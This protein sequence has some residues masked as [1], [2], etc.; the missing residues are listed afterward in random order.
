MQKKVSRYMLDK[1][2]SRMAKRFGTIPKGEEDPYYLQMYSMEGNLLKLHRRDPSKNG[3]DALEA[4]GMC[5]LTVDGYLQDL[6]YDFNSVSNDK[7]SVFCRGLLMSFDPFTN[8]EVKEVL[9]SEYDWNAKKVKEEY[10]EAPIKCILR[11]AKSI[12]LWTEEFGPNG[13]FIFMED[14]IGKLVGDNDELDFAV[15]A[16][17]SEELVRELEK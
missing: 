4:V 12:S 11:I 15:R 16:P 13:Y 8:E 14:Q 9:G 1:I 2:G 7:N 5:L 6:E 17:L 3:N 10:Y